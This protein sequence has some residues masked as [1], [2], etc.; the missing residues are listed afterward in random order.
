ME[1]QEIRPQYQ[2]PEFWNW[3]ENNGN[4]LDFD[5]EELLDWP[6]DDI[7]GSYPV[8][9]TVDFTAKERIKAYIK[10]RNYLEENALLI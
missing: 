8:F 7:A 4:W 9:E 10:V 2:H 1:F 5:T 3:V 6:V